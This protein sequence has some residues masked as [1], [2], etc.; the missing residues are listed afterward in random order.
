MK[1]LREHCF[2]TRIRV[3]RIWTNSG[4]IK[5]SLTLVQDTHKGH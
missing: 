2:F 5:P 1:Q 4:I 3:S